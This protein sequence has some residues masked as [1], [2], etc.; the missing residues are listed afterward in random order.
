MRKLLIIAALGIL[1]VAVTAQSFPVPEGCEGVVT[2]QQRGCIMVNVWQ[3]EA[4]PVGD[5]WLA[6][7]TQSGPFS[8]QHVD[9]EFQW[10]ESFKM[11]GNE[12][13]VQPATDPASMTELLENGLD[14]F[15]F[16][17]KK[18]AGTERNVGFDALT[19]V[20]MKIDGEP[21]LQ[22]EFEGRTF[23]ADGNELDHGAGRQYVSAKHRIFFFGES[24]NPET[25]DQIVD[26]SPVEFIY[27]G[28]D[29]F[30]SA[31][32]KF[33]CNEIDTRFSQ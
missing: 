25:P 5:K 19:G 7:F 3:C 9:R 24:W 23:D 16:E 27:P 1:P 33:E 13:L 20:E 4:D 10:L 17:I 28:E 32:P 11:T 2:V 18:P 15:E 14:T 30:F 31:N 26:M 6:L 12:T 8:I 22:T 29:G 21:L